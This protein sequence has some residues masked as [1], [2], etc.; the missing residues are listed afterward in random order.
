MKELLELEDRPTGVILGNYNTMLGGIM[1]L[2]ESGLSCPQDVSLIGV[3]NLPM[4]QVLRPK[5]WLIVQPMENDVREGCSY[6]PG[7]SKWR[8]KRYAGKKLV[9]VPL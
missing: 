8:A 5:L 1:A 2:N 4:T 3:D 9:S 7:A 6:A